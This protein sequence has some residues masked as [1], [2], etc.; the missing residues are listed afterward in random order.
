MAYGILVASFNVEDFSLD[1][2][3]ADRPQRPRAADGAVS[4]D[5]ELLDHLS[6]A[7]DH[8]HGPHSHLYRRR[9]GRQRD[10]AGRRVDRQAAR[11]G[12]GGELGQ[13]AAH[14][15]DAQVSGGRAGY[16]DARHLP[17]RRKPR[18]RQFEPFEITCRGAGAFPTAEQPRTLWI[19]IEDGAEALCELQAAVEEALKQELGFAKE[20][21]AIPAA[22]D[23]RPRQA[24]AAVRQRR[25]GR[26][27][28]R[29]TP[30]S[31]PTW[32]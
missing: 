25:T 3:Q 20:A 24:R 1:R 30:I 27:A 14:A 15:P 31:T 10:V 11:G 19:G 13:A 4:E 23:D 32:P 7:F 6:L 5:A 28:R 2:M 29:S 12:G 22:P 8:S 9:A 16:R 21:R 26:A 18:P 17:G